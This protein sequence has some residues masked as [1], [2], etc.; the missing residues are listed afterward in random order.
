MIL[1]VWTMPVVLALR[2]LREEAVAWA[3]EPNP[4]SK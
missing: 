2:K 3:T 1:D 4:T